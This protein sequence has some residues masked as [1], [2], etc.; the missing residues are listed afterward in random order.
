MSGGGRLTTPRLGAVL[1]GACILMAAG[2]STAAQ[3][4]GLSMSCHELLGGV[5][6]RTP[7]V[8]DVVGANLFRTSVEGERII[9]SSAG[10]R[11]YLSTSRDK[12][13]TIQS[14]ASHVLHGQVLDRQVFER[15]DGGPY[16]LRFTERFDFAAQRYTSS[17]SGAA[18]QC[19]HLV[20][21]RR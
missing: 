15:G 7:I 3:P 1:F 11:R 19:H 18:D 21:P 9:I 16:R 12:G 4:A 13:R 10:D 2:G 6:L 5:P 20:P 17:F 14:Y 8:Y